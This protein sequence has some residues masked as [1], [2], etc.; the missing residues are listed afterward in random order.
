[1]CTYIDIM[2]RLGELLKVS[3]TDLVLDFF[4]ITFLRDGVIDGASNTLGV[5]L[6]ELNPACA[7]PSGMLPVMLSLT[8]AAQK[9]VIAKV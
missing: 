7:R 9:V 8:L 2:A 1:M 6:L 5:R 3:P 4:D